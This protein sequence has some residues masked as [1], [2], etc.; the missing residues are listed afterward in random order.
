MLSRLD[1]LEGHPVIY[2]RTDI[3]CLLLTADSK[4]D[5][6]KVKCQIYFLTD[7]KPSLLDLPF[8]SDYRDSA[9]KPFLPGGT[10]SSFVEEVKIS[11]S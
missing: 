2:L 1:Q 4:L 11:K 7:F 9:E 3:D 6:T 10:E 8:I 5:A